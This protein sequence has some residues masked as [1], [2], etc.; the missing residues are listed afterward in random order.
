MKPATRDSSL[1]TKSQRKLC[2]WGL[3]WKK[4]KAKDTGI[5]FRL[6]NILLRGNPDTSFSGP[7]CH[8]CHKP[9]NS[10]LMYICCETCKDWYHAEAVELEESKIFDLVGFKCCRCRRIKSPMC[11]YMDPEIKKQLEVR[12]PRTRAP[13]LGKSGMDLDTG[14][15]SELPKEGEP[16]TPVLCTMEE[17]CIQDDPLLFSL[18]RVERSTELNSKVDLKWNTANASGFGPHK[19]PVRRHMKCE[20]DVNGFS[21]NNPSHIDLSA[22]LEANKLPIPTEES[23]SPHVECDASTNGFEDGMMFNYDNLNCED[24]E[25]EPQTYFSFTELLASDDDD[26][27]DEVDA[28]RDV[29]GHSENLYALPWDGNMEQYGMGTSSDQQEPTIPVEP[30]GDIVPCRKCSHTE[31]C[32]DLSCQICGLRIHSHC[33]P[34]VEQ[35]SWEG[36]WRCGNCRDWR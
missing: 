14:K 15:I 29:S 10:D 11:P 32:P 21:E 22:N 17:V 7:V 28:S 12:K 6:K 36:S 16:T 20:S 8:L 3:I 26:H 23:L 9:Y 2:S 33:S 13:K 30:A 18:S 34:W 27:L 35:S 24:T 5:D 19:L 1:V 25:F 31:P 4:K